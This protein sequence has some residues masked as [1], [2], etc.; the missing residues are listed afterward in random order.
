M[1]NNSSNIAVYPGD[2]LGTDIMQA[3]EAVLRHAEASVGG[4]S[5]LT[6]MSIP[7]AQRITRNTRRTSRQPNFR[8]TVRPMRFLDIAR[9]YAYAPPRSAWCAIPGTVLV[10]ESMF[11]DILSGLSADSVG[12]MGLGSCA[13][14]GTGMGCSIRPAVQRQT[15][16]AKVSPNRLP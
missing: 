16:G 7:R 6:S 15:S 11:G 14:M 8:R 4:F 12:A 9:R 5:R 2:G 1:Q 13:D 3:A 10:V